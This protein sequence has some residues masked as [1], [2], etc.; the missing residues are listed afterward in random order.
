MAN[1]ALMM[2]S[3]QEITYIIV[4]DRIESNLGADHCM[5]GITDQLTASTT[6]MYG[7]LLPPMWEEYCIPELLLLEKEFTLPQW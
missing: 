7:L 6:H 3:T 2:M 5:I 4:A 1:M